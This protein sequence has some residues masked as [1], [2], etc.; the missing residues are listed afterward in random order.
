MRPDKGFAAI[1][2]LFVLVVLAGLGVALVTIFGGQQR[3]QANDILGMR[4]YQAARAGI[5]YGLYQAIQNASCATTTFALDDL[6]TGFSVKV[7]CTGGATTYTD[8]GTVKVYQ[9]T[10]TGCNRA[11]CPAAAT[12]GYVERELRASACTGNC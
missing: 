11:G 12:D 1:S 10:A 5:E 6:L 7:E 3:S 2:A 4:A 8:A 9:I